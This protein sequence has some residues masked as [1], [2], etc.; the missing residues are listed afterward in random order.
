MERP[1]KCLLS[2]QF[3]RDW[4]PDR[5]TSY[6]NNLHPQKHKDLYGIIEDIISCAI[7]LWNASLSPLRNNHHATL[8][9]PYTEVEYDLNFYRD[10][11]ATEGPQREPNET[12][13][14]FWKR[15]QPWAE[16]KEE[17]IKENRNLVLPEPPEFS[18]SILKIMNPATSLDAT[19]TE[20]TVDLLRDYGKRGL[21]VIV[22]LANICLTPERPQYEGGTWHV[23]GQIVSAFVTEVFPFSPECLEW[24]YLCLRSLLLLLSQHHTQS[25]RFPSTSWRRGSLFGNQLWAKWA[26]LVGAHLWMRTRWTRNSSGRKCRDEGRK[27]CHLPEYSAAPGSAVQITRS[28]QTG[29]AKDRRALSG[30]SECSHYFDCQC[31]VSADG[32]VGRGGLKRQRKRW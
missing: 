28:H 21:Q 32:M 26:W 10:V 27:T 6:I 14:E 11:P 24:A 17:W 19:L 15:R 16:E 3:S 12:D 31:S 20:E 30:G 8:R 9:I 25:S 18:P 1:S 2:V 5:I 29:M 23:E 13:W 7:P 4:P 22:K